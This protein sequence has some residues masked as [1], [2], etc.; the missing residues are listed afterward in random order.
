MSDAPRP[1]KDA[2]TPFSGQP[3]PQETYPASDL[4]LRSC[5]GV[6]FHVHKQILACVFVFFS[7]MFAFHS[8]SAPPTEIERDGNS[9]LVLLETE[10]V[11][12]RRL[13]LAYPARSR[14]PYSLSAA[15]LDSACAVHEASAEIPLPI[16][17]ENLA[18]PEMRLIS[19]E[20]LQ[21]LYEFHRLCSKTT[22][23]ILK[24]ICACLDDEEI[25]LAVDDDEDVHP[26]TT[27]TCTRRRRRRAPG[28]DEDVHPAT[29]KTCTRRTDF[30]S[31]ST[32]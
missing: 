20:N 23:G 15:D 3:D 30:G 32:W 11:I 21:T 16:C 13:I 8:C 6:D 10:D 5:D 25:G 17:P 22:R 27:K 24:D 12:Y 31:S 2:Q 19:A 7:D 14:Q 28:D 4:I 26:A 9:V 1:T 29:T 18:F